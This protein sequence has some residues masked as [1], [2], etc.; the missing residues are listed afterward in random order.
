MPDSTATVFIATSLDGFI[1]REDGGID[2]LN[3][4]PDPPDE[5]YGYA[6][7]MASVDALVMG[8]KTWD[9]VRGLP[10]WPYGKKP[11]IVLSSKKVDIPR[12]LAKLV[13]HM[14]G[15]PEAIINTLATRELHHL[16]VDGGVT[17]QRFLNAG[18]IHRL[19]ITRIPVL[20]G[21]GIPLFGALNGGDIRLRHVAT[22]TY[23]NGLVQSEYTIAA[24]RRP[25]RRTR[26]SRAVK[27][28]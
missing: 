13:T 20:I 6:A 16:Y 25:T 28:A 23:S 8:R 14:S 4:T 11:V 27:K 9:F 1:A 21:S 15:K 12:E 10:A 18:A 7:H 2:W 19:I 17:I 22:R 5:D 24:K 26:A 3:E